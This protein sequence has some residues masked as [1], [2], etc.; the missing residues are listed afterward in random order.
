MP[1]SR[2][3]DPFQQGEKTSASKLEGLR[4]G[5]AKRIRGLLGRES[6]TSASF[7]QTD[8]S[9]RETLE[10]LNDTGLT[11]PAYSLF[12]VKKSGLLNYPWGPPVRTESYS[13]E[14]GLNYV[15]NYDFG[16][17]TGQPY[18]CQTVGHLP[19]LIRYTADDGLPKIGHPIGPLEDGSVS[20]KRC[21]YVVI[22]AP[23]TTNERV[24]IVKSNDHLIRVKIVD[25]IE[26]T[27]RGSVEVQGEELCGQES[28]VPDPDLVAP[29]RPFVIDE[30]LNLT[31]VI[32]K[33]DTFHY[34]KPILGI[35]L[36]IIGE[37][38]PIFKVEAT[39]C[40]Y[41]EDEGDFNLLQLN[42]ESDEFEPVVNVVVTI[43]DDYGR[44]MLLPGEI[45]DAAI[46]LDECG[47][48]KFKLIG[49]YG[50]VRQAKTLEDIACFSTGSVS[51]LGHELSDCD[52]TPY[53]PVTACNGATGEEGRRNLFTDEAV[54]VIYF[55][56]VWKILAQ[57]IATE[58]LGTLT[59][60]LCPEDAVG[61]ANIDETLGYCDGAN[62]LQGSVSFDNLFGLSG[63]AGKRVLL[64][65][66]INQGNVV[67]FAKQVGHV[68]KS[69]PVLEG[70]CDGQG[71]FLRYGSCKI[72]GY[73]LRKTSQMFCG[74]SDWELQIQLYEHVVLADASLTGAGD[75][76]NYDLTGV[77]DTFCVF[78]PQEVDPP[79]IEL[80]ST[81]FTTA[82]VYSDLQLE[83]DPGASGSQDECALPTLRLTGSAVEA[84]IC[85][86]GGGQSA[87]IGTPL[88]LSS[89]PAYYRAGTTTDSNGRKCVVLYLADIVSFGECNI[90]GD[91]DE[92]ICGNPCPEDASPSPSQ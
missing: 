29:A 59:A 60:D 78:E 58:W 42:I 83:Y 13:F 65:A 3:V 8:T 91:S 43:Q 90:D 44:F 12:A 61:Q 68:C 21:G 39:D 28:G 31:G 32:L 9:I 49:S 56:S 17:A 73:V 11:I 47:E 27:K 7:N 15:T 35:G 33:A 41:P 37:Y 4:K 2:N 55:E 24:W 87:T 57:P 23:D 20:I 30:V 82:T 48:A 64:G 81:D 40:F 19:V 36:C 22:A 62:G 72:E 85:G 38:D 84:V 26:P 76:C 86:A 70:D 92:I 18:T 50:L 16:I 63:T 45:A 25:D 53:C 34:A 71:K 69:I 52:G 80:G 10:I 6:S 75:Y 74:D 88:A 51:I 54:T 1:T 77:P 14:A 5:A 46:Y 67:G 89:S 66:H 79:A